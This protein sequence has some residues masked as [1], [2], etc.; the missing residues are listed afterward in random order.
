MELKFGQLLDRLLKAGPSI[1]PGGIE[2]GAGRVLEEAGAR[3]QSDQVELKCGEGV[4]LAGNLRPSIGPGGIEISSLGAK[5]FV[6]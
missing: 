2:I 5:V 6:V 3:L 4:A 1:G